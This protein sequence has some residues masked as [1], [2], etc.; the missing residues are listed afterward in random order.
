M[1]II[2]YQNKSEDLNCTCVECRM[3]MIIKG[4]KFSK[5]QIK[6]KNKIP[7]TKKPGNTMF[8]VGL[9]SKMRGF[10]PSSAGVKVD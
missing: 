9:E 10:E 8:S 2:T 5:R 4:G 6:G 1:S 3:G 7:H